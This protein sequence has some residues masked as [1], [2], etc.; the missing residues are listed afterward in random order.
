MSDRPQKQRWI[1]K[2]QEAKTIICG[3]SGC[4][5][6]KFYIHNFIIMYL[7]NRMFQL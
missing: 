2:E 7:F 3:F 4:A 1:L 5:G 6:G